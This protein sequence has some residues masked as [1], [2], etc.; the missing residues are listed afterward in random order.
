[1]RSAAAPAPASVAQRDSV[2][3]RG[4]FSRRAVRVPSVT[5]H[6]S[7]YREHSVRWLQADLRH[8]QDV[9]EERALLLIQLEGRL[10]AQRD[11]AARGVDA[12][13]LGAQQR[14]AQDILVRIADLRARV[15]RMQRELQR[16]ARS[17]AVSTVRDAGERA[18]ERSGVRVTEAYRRSLVPSRGPQRG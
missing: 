3:P 14:A 1:M 9:L 7:E 18:P 16:E 4:D 12:E 6:C 13:E 8:T 15:A 5:V 17:A 2:L 11:G 10:I